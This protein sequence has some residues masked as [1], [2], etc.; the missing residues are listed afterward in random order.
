MK[1][2]NL[3]GIGQAS[4]ERG[5]G[6]GEFTLGRTGTPLSLAQNTGRLEDPRRQ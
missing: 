3:S 5:P 6:W 4:K 2:S 1:V